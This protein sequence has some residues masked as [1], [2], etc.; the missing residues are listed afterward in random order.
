MKLSLA[1]IV[2]NEAKYIER[3]LNS[4][5]ST[6]DEIIVVDTGS[7]D[8]TKLIAQKCG[9]QVFDFAWCDDFSAARNFSLEQTT[10]DWILVL[11]ADEFV[12][13]D[14]RKDIENF[15]TKTPQAVG[16]IK[17]LNKTTKDGIEVLS[18]CNLTRLFP[19]GCK[20][21]GYVHEQVD[22]DLPRLQTSIVVK[23]DGYLYD[24]KV[25]RNLTLLI[26]ALEDNPNDSYYLYQTGK[27]YFISEDYL[28]AIPYFE[29]AFSNGNSN[30]QHI[31]SLVVDMIFACMKTQNYEKGLDF[32]DYG[33]EN[34]PN[35]PDLYYTC[36]IFFMEAAAKYPNQYTHLIP[37]IE[38]A[39]LNALSL[40]EAENSDG[41]IGAGSYLSAHNLAAFYE[42]FGR[43]AEAEDY[44]QKE[45]EMRCLFH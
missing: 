44:Y 5:K 16:K 24:N 23:H 15:I 13:R 40:G 38:I 32:I 22:T 30:S 17:Q 28:Q 31:Q 7:T 27:Q 18:E 3:C 4:I 10:G 19:Q 37:Q 20:F 2:K 1:M 11:D 36:G 42:A 21:I 33:L 39:Y 14:Y 25:P 45:Q 12:E 26:K 6:V 35:R 41:I 29:K 8:N 34:Y 9:A 43:A